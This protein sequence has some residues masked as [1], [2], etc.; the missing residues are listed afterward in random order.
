MEELLF[1]FNT[2]A[3]LLL[4]VLIGVFLQKIKLLPDTFYA[5]AE[6]FVF[7]A[8]LP[9]SLFMNVYNADVSETFNPK[10]ILFCLIGVVFTFVLPCLIIPLFVKGD[11]QRGAFIHGAFR[12]NFAI[13]GLPLAQRLHPANGGAVVSSIMPFSIPLFNIFAVTI[14]SIFAPSEKKLTPA[15]ITKKAVKGI[16][17]NPLIIG[18]VLGLPFMLT[19]L[20]L[21]SFATATINYV[22]GVTTPIAMICLGAN[23]GS[24]KSKGKIG[25]ALSAALTKVIVFPLILVTA[26]ALIGFRGVELGAILIL[27]GGP[28][29]V[30]SYIMAKNMDS[31]H[32]MAGQILLLSTALCSI[33]M[34]IGIYV[35]K[36]LGML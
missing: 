25:L 26:G 8:A 21:P 2:V 36:T 6:K 32:E 11:Q 22:G 28:T 5:Q 29:A 9:C 23:M 35:L 12:S 13:F 24:Y 4:L 15:Q 19:S 14:L 3:P 17:T 7:R 30:S 1:S 27:F 10:L 31:D 16:I 33:T 18:I 20:S 34:F